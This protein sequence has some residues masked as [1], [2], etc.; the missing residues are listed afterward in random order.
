MTSPDQPDY[1]YDENRLGKELAEL[2]ERE[3]ALSQEMDGAN[4]LDLGL[5]GPE[6][7]AGHELNDLQRRRERLSAALDLAKRGY[8]LWEAW[9]FQH[10]VTCA[11]GE[12]LEWDEVSEALTSGI[13]SGSAGALVRMPLE[14]QGAYARAHFTGLFRGFV[15]ATTYSTEEVMDDLTGKTEWVSIRP[16]SHYWFGRAASVA[17]HDDDLFHIAGWSGDE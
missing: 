16:F 11:C 9:G 3:Q 13:S 5:L 4:D 8:D 10:T 12:H 14:I 15:V 1:I 6:R 7:A 17:A 2:D